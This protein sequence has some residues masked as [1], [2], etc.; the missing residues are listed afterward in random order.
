MIGPRQTSTS[1]P[2][3]GRPLVGLEPGSGKGGRG[4]TTVVGRSIVPYAPGGGT[5]V[6]TRALAKRLAEQTG[7]PFVVENHGG[8][9]AGTGTTQAQDSLLDYLLGGNS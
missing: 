6:L 1:R 5:D 4:G 8:A 9:G 2:A 3:D 7:Q